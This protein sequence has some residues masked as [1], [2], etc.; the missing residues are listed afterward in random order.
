MRMPESQK[1][2]SRKDDDRDEEEKQIYNSMVGAGNKGVA[3]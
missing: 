1:V 2:A 3:E